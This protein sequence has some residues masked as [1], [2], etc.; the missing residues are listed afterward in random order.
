ML[1]ADAAPPTKAVETWL[2]ILAIIGF[3][4]V[5]LNRPTAVFG[6]LSPAV[7]PVYIVHMPVQFLLSALLLNGPLPAPIE[8]VVLFVTTVAVS[9]GLYEGVRRVRWLRPLFGLAYSSG[10]STQP[11]VP[12]VPPAGVKGRGV[13]T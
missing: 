10:G 7:Y 2:W 11:V 6:Y 12:P 5:H 1:V 9:L 4:A 8:L 3:G 13:S